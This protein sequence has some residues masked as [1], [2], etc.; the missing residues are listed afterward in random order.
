MD[1]LTITLENDQKV[2]LFNHP[3]R[4]LGSFII[5]YD[6]LPTPFESLV[7][8]GVTALNCDFILRLIESGS[9]GLR[10][11]DQHTFAFFERSEDRDQCER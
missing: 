1:T 5:V 11:D 10:F 7:G 2:E 3:P 8:A 9:L 4:G 6:T